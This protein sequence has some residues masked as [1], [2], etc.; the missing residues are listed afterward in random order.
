VE[1]AS[2][3]ERESLSINESIASLCSPGLFGIAMET[4]AAD[5]RVGRAVVVTVVT[6][7]SEVHVVVT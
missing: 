6:T 3:P 2:G 5:E 7:L 1:C 4:H